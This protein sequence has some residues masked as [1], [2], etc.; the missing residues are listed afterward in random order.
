MSQI[1]VIVPVYN[2]EP[3]LQRCV[4]SILR[5][6]YKDFELILVDDGSPDNCP[7][8]CD[9]Y[10]KKDSRVVVIH[11][12]NGGLSAARNAGIDWSFANSDSQWL[13]FIDSDDWVHQDFLKCLLDAA[14]RH[15]TLISQC[16]DQCVNSEADI[17][18]PDGD[19]FSRVASPSEVYLMWESVAAVRKLIHK[20]LMKNIRY[21]I[22]K[23]HEDEYT[24]Y[25][26]LFSTEK[27]AV[28]ENANY[29][30]YFLRP[31]SIMRSV[32]TPR[33]LDVMQAY[34]NQLYFFKNRGL[35]KVELYVAGCYI[36]NIVQQYT[37]CQTIKFV[38]KTKTLKILRVKLLSLLDKYR[39][40]LS[41][42][43]VT[44]PQVYEVAYPKL[45]YVYW[46]FKGIIG[47]IR[48]LLR[49]S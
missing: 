17:I 33:H 13:T 27:I 38:Q 45:M 43:I 6:T 8:I 24:T 15:D 16:G 36:N 30:Y 14:N 7:A 21:P 4:E 35:E 32:Y 42:S 11:Q 1:S 47:K 28:I 26:I 29:Y 39:N 5:Q 40:K 31:D 22:N 9:E 12:K 20:K 3:Y 44:T 37:Q 10:A 19:S 25:R 48:R 46:Q 18:L 49:N 23:L 41:L 2:V 34:E